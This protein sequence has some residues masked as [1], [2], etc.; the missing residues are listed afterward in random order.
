MWHQHQ[1]TVAEK[2]IRN[3]KANYSDTEQL[4]TGSVFRRDC[5]TILNKYTGKFPIGIFSNMQD[6]NGFLVY[7]FY[8]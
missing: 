5:R 7:F 8:N 4:P 2:K 3:C 6:C 1:P